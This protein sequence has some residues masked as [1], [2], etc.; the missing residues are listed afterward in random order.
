MDPDP[1]IHLPRVPRPRDSS[2]GNQA[3][4]FTA[5]IVIGRQDAEHLAGAEVVGPKIQRP[6]LVRALMADKRHDQI[7][8]ETIFW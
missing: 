4:V 3:E 6:P 1:S 2:I 8:R 7:G 5:A